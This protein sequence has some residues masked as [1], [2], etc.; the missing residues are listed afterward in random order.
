LKYGKV[1]IYAM[2]SWS[3]ICAMI[4]TFVREQQEKDRLP[5]YTMHAGWSVLVL[6]AMGQVHRRLKKN[7]GFNAQAQLALTRQKTQKSG[8]LARKRHLPLAVAPAAVS[9]AHNPPSKPMS[10]NTE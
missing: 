3:A 7:Q 9:G 10:L 6:L 4:S 2:S 5:V 1:L 8:T